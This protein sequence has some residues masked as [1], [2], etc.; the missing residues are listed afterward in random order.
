MCMRYHDF[1]LL[2]KGDLKRLGGGSERKDLLKQILIGESFKLI[3]WYRVVSFLRLNNRIVLE[4]V[5]VRF[6]RYYRYKYNITLPIE[7][8][9]GDGLFM[10]H[11]GSIVINGSTK[12]GRNVN[13]SQGVTIGVSRRGKVGVPVIGD[14]VFIGPGAVI[15]GKISI[16]NNVAIGANSVVNFDVLDG[17]VVAGNPGRIVSMNGSSGYINNKASG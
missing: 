7:T 15:V 1:K 11:V 12:I 6:W 16:G 3:F 14:D 9:V 2:V 4:K 10:P 5:A 17:A 13:I 8:V